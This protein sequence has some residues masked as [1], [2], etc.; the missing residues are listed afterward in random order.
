MKTFPFALLLFLLLFLFLG[1][2]VWAS[3][4]SKLDSEPLKIGISFAPPF[5]ITSASDITG[6]SIDLWEQIADS[7][8]IPFEYRVFPTY[9]S[10]ISALEN[11]EI[12]L[13]ANPITLTD[14]RLIHYNL[15]LP[16]YTS[17]MGIVERIGNVYPLVEALKHLFRWPT[18]RLILMLFF[19]VILFAF[20][21]WLAER[22]KNHDQFRKGFK[23]ITDGIWWAFVTMTT[24]GYGDKVPLSKAG[25]ILTIVWMFYAIALFFLVTAEISS[26]LT[27][28]KLQSDVTSI[29]DLRK[30]KLGTLDQTGYASMCIKNNIGYVPFTSL[31]EG[32]QAVEKK[33]IDIFIYDAA[34]LEYTIQ[35]E[36]LGNKLMVTPSDLSTQYFCYAATK[37][38]GELMEK[39]NVVLFNIMESPSW[40]TI[41]HQYNVER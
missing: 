36:S 31:E 3:A 23:G 27:V 12:D 15:S 28:N 8:K 30:A 11:E 20:L 2:G 24:V 6:V 13:T 40:Y 37:S 25:R 34:V 33:K 4:T 22:R 16:F 19:V 32:L 14:Y 38:Y 26:E 18:L 41:L 7:L 17:R 39:I 21:I 10:L 29:E 1:S 9:V 35:K 5:T